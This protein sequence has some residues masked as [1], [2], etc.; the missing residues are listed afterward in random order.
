MTGKN[1]LL[2]YHISEKLKYISFVENFIDAFDI[3]DYLDDN[4]FSDF[5]ILH[6]EKKL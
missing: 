4:E 2:L 3:I 5:L 1:Y 6:F